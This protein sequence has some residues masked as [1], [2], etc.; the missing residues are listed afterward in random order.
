MG[1]WDPKWLTAVPAY[2]G[3]VGGRGVPIRYRRIYTCEKNKST[4][5]HIPDTHPYTVTGIRILPTMRKITVLRN[6]VW[7]LLTMVQVLYCA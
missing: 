3:G 5:M 6:V 7:L 4:V 1:V 2:G